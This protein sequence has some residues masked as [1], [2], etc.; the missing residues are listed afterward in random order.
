MADYADDVRSVLD[1]LNIHP[2]LIGHSLGGLIVQMV[3]ASHVSVRALALVGSAGPAALG[4]TRDFAW[5]EDKPLLF[6]PERMRQSMFCEIG[7]GEFA[8]INGRLVAESPRAL[9]DSGLAG[10]H[11]AREAISSPVL[12][13]GTEHDGIGLHKGEDIAAY[14][15][16]DLIEIPG[17]S[18]DCLVEDAGLDAAYE[19]IRW[20]MAKKLDREDS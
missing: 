6:P 15:R 8:A 17:T 19:I 3:A 1:S 5:P 7:D 9:N 12:V 16:A 14:Y 2:V 20:L 10:V 18:H 4:A 13:I 11:V